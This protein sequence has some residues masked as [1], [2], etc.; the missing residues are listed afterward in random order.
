MSTLKAPSVTITFAAAAV[1]AVQRSTKGTVALIL[2]DAALSDKTYSL[3]SAKQIPAGLGATNQAAVS[4]AFLGYVNP[5]MRVLLYV[6]NSTD[7]LAANSAA[8][9]WLA[10]QNFDYLAGPPDLSAAEAAVIKAWI[11][12]QRTNNHAIYKAVLPNTSADSE[13]IVNFAA[14]GIVTGDGTFDTAAYCGRIAGLLAGT[15]MT[16]SGTYAPLPEAEDVTRLTGDARDTEVGA[17]KLI[18]MWDGEKVKLVRAVN[19]LQTV[20]SPKTDDWKYIK[21][22]ELID[23]VTH[24]IRKAAEDSFIG[25]YPNSYDSKLLLVTAITDYLSTLQKSGLIEDGYLCQIDVDAQEAYLKTQG[26]DT[27]SLTEQQIKEHNTGT[28]VFLAI[29]LTPINAIEDISVSITL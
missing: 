3:T 22:M 7:V 29:S 9:V 28:Q 11:T 21:I 6:M 24:D 25:K 13:A 8:L 5:P 15:P 10:T 16:I 19:S 26:V 18:L 1:S 23:M 27:G 4:R 12:D 14:D 17:G 20:T 2:R